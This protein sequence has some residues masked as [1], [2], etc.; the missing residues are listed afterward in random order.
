MKISKY[1]V[2]LLLACLLAGCATS[3]QDARNP[4]LG[5]KGGYWDRPGPGQLF[6]VGFSGNGFTDT[7]KVGAFLLYHA[8][9]VVKRE[10]KV[11]FT[12]Y[13]SLPDAIVDRRT[14]ERTIHTIFGKPDGFVYILL[15]DAPGPNVLVADEVFERYKNEI[16]PTGA[17]S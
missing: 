6:K 13:T 9:E 11:Y 1:A 7:A 10:N 4:L 16:A 8:A 5:W 2:G 15:R 12:M 3:Y 17:G 14:T